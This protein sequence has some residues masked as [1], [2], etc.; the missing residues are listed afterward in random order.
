MLLSHKYRVLFIHIPKTA[1]RSIR[2]AFKEIDPS[3]EKWLPGLPERPRHVTAAEVKAAFP[4]FASFTSIAVVRNPFDRFCSLYYF[5]RGQSDYRE[6]MESVNSLDDFAALFSG[7]SWVEKL[8][9]T[10]PQT[11]Y[12]ND[13]NGRRLVSTVMRFE[14][15]ADDA[16]ELGKSIGRP[17]RLP[18]RNQSNRDG[19]SYRDVITPLC[20]AV[21]EQRYA[22]DLSELGYAF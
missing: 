11:A 16:A 2:A 4:D 6:Q 7:G 8:Y 18:L 13:A 20:R 22:S 10:M 3:A 5:L 17:L 1:G 19:R 9:S 12:L 21:V 15:L 14:R